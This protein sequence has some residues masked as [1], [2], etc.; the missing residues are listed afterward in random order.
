MQI[1]C[2]FS[3]HLMGMYLIFVVFCK[4]WKYL[5]FP[6]CGFCVQKREAF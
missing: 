4:W 2:V 6:D 5:A 1:K 3:Y